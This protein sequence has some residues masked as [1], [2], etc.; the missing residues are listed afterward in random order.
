MSFRAGD[1]VYHRPSNER[2]VLALDEN[3]G[4]VSWCGWPE[5]Q[6]RASDCDL[7]H[8]ATDEERMK[9]LRDVAGGSG[10]RDDGTL[11][12]RKLMAMAALGAAE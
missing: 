9:M 3:Q 1:S 10:R 6:A 11:D 4:Y 5:G 2:W 12:H 8:A 7:L